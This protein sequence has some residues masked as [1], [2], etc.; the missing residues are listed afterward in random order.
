[1]FQK[2]ITN[3][4]QDVTIA[5]KIWGEASDKTP[6]YAENVTVI[7]NISVEKISMAVFK[8]DKYG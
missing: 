6:V 5:D 4:R 3:S 2:L 1:M 8:C 7:Y